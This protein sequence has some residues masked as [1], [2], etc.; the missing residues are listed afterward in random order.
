MAMVRTPV[1]GGERMLSECPTSSRDPS[2]VVQAGR[3]EKAV[4]VCNVTG[5]IT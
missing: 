1:V 2:M 3:T 5:P 4:T